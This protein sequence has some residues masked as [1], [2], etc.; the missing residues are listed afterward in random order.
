MLTS[1]FQ[2]LVAAFRSPRTQSSSMPP[3]R[4]GR[5][6][7]VT[8]N[9]GGREGAVN[10][11]DDTRPPSGRTQGEFREGGEDAD[12]SGSS[13]TFDR[14]DDRKAI[15]RNYVGSKGK[16]PD[17]RGA[18][19]DSAGGGMKNEYWNLIACAILDYV[20]N[21]LTKEN[22]QP[23]TVA[24]GVA[25][26]YLTYSWNRASGKYQ[27]NQPQDFRKISNVM[28][29][30]VQSPSGYCNRQGGI[31]T[32]TELLKHGKNVCTDEFLR[33]IGYG[34][35]LPP[36]RLTEQGT[37]S[38]ANVE[39]KPQT[40]ARRNTRSSPIQ[41]KL[42]GSEVL[43][44]GFE[45]SADVETTTLWGRESRKTGKHGLG[46]QVNTSMAYP[47]SQNGDGLKR[48]ASQSLSPPKKR[49]R[50]PGDENDNLATP[51]TWHRAQPPGHQLPYYVTCSPQTSIPFS[52]STDFYLN[53]DLLQDEIQH[54]YDAITSFVYRNIFRD[55]GLSFKMLAAFVPR[56]KCDSGLSR[57]YETLLGRRLV[58]WRQRYIN[59]V[60]LATE[61]MIALIGAFLHSR[62]FAYSEVETADQW[63]EAVQAPVD[64][65]LPMVERQLRSFGR[66]LK[67]Y[68]IETRLT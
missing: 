61:L 12:L 44:T 8:H 49:S 3:T 6:A 63:L 67:P 55:Q 37:S 9:K 2:T 42:R 21:D 20:D 29:Q 66:R 35:R 48:K 31:T 28:S 15:Q 16:Y 5:S 68:S 60:M 19:D 56:T 11:K 65:K 53:D 13:G 59:S 23:V 17:S 54:L 25:L 43:E 34:T 62:V 52:D 22:A 32:Q 50:P 18:L 57:L 51:T 4:Q 38:A 39:E 10:V 45:L 47:Q 24:K 58:D 46:S 7:S 26:K 14:P 41:R 64:R 40:K 1:V 30:I 33:Q 36:L 27:E